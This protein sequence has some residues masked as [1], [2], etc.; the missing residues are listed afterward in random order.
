MIIPPSNC[1]NT[2]KGN[3]CSGFVDFMAL[4]RSCKH[5]FALDI[6]FFAALEYFYN[7]KE[8]I[9]VHHQE[10]AHCSTQK[11]EKLLTCRIIIIE[12]NSSI[13]T[14]LHETINK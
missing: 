10:S 11:Q 7:K 4:I 12:Y 6:K 2:S 8:H 13:L 5:N 1:I 9:L 14:A 3:C